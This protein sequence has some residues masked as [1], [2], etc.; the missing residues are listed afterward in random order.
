MHILAI[1]ILGC[2][3]TVNADIYQCERA[4]GSVYYQDTTCAIPAER[5]TKL[6]CQVDPVP[7][8]TLDR[9]QHDHQQRVKKQKRQQKSANKQATQERKKRAKKHAQC[10]KAKDEIAKIREEYRRGYTAK[11]GKMLDKR[12]A[13]QKLKRQQHCVDS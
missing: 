7:K 2:A 12:L 9:L 13:E 10:A 4:D 5:Q 3:F 6:L 8:N 11:R 1:I